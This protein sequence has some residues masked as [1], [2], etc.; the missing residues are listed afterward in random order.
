MVPLLF[1]AF[2]YRR[3]PLSTFAYAMIFGFLLVHEWG[4]DESVAADDAESLRPGE[5]F[6]V[7]ILS[8]R[9]AAGGVCG[10]G[11]ALAEKN[12]IDPRLNH[13]AVPRQ[14]G[15]GGN[16]VFEP[17]FRRRSENGRRAKR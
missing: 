4:A 5:P 10:G 17:V 1:L 12:L 11:G 8:E 2:T 3:I 7:R 16:D 9:A 13:F 14:E 15:N 6:C